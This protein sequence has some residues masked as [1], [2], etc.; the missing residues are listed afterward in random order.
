[1]EKG[2]PKIVWMKCRAKG[3]LDQRS[4][5]GTQAV[6]SFDIKLPSGGK[7]SRFRCVKCGRTF[8]VTY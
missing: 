3:V 1:M 2:A 6:A 4:C 8:G 7:L 5:D